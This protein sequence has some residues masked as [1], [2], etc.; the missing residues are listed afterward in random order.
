M[1]KKARTALSDALMLLNR[2][3]YSQNELVQKLVQKGHPQEKSLEVVVDLASKD[4][5]SDKRALRSLVAGGFYSKHGPQRILLNAIN[6][7]F[8]SEDTKL[9]LED[10]QEQHKQ[11]PDQSC[12]EEQAQ[13]LVERHFGKP[14]YDF[15]TQTKIMRRL[16]GKGYA[17]DLVQKLAKSSGE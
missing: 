1:T 17:Y 14:P 4:I 12:W 11:D 16:L 6:K 5:Q 7:G 3:E 13:H 15:A 10:W 9:A 8:S 2:R